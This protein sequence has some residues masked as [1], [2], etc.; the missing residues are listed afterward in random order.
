VVATP[1][2][3]RDSASVK[4][5][6]VPPGVRYVPY[7]QVPADACSMLA[8][9]VWVSRCIDSGLT[10]ALADET[11]MPAAPIEAPCGEAAT[12]RVRAV[13]SLQQCLPRPLAWAAIGKQRRRRIISLVCLTCD[14]VRTDEHT[15]AT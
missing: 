5:G 12:H 13:L 1:V 8:N 6:G 15:M 10:S 2:Y 7:R 3:P 11:C 4:G 9:D 14:A